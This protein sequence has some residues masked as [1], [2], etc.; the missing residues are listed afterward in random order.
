MM[1]FFGKGKKGG[2]SKRRGSRQPMPQQ[3]AIDFSSPDAFSEENMAKV[4]TTRWHMARSV[5]S[6]LP[7]LVFMRRGGDRILFC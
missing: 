3:P 4:R 7:R 6:L 1:N 5:A 2:S